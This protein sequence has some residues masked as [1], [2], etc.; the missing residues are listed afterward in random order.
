MIIPTLSNN[1]YL[2]AVN[3]HRQ[4]WLTEM[5]RRKAFML[6]VALFAVITIGV[7]AYILQ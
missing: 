5:E 1:G 4:R 7:L 3:R 2:Y 6:M